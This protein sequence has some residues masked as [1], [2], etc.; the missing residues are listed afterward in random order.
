MNIKFSLHFYFL[1]LIICFIYACSNDSRSKTS[2]HIGFTK[3]NVKIPFGENLLNQTY[4]GSSV[5]RTDTSELLY[6]Y[7][8]QKDRLQVFNLS[9]ME[10]SRVIDWE[11]SGS[12]AI[13]GGR[14]NFLGDDTIIFAKPH[15]VYLMN[16]RG[17]KIHQYR[18]S[19]ELSSIKVKNIDYSKYTL[20]PRGQTLYNPSSKLSYFYLFR[21]IS[22]TK[23]EFYNQPVFAAVDWKKGEVKE[24]LSFTYPKRLKLED[25]VYDIGAL[26]P[27]LLMHNDTLIYNFPCSSDIYFYDLKTKKGSFIEADSKF[28]PKYSQTIPLNEY[29]NQENHKKFIDFYLDYRELYYDSYRQL[30]YRVHHIVEKNSS[31]DK[32]PMKVYLTVFNRNFD[33]LTEI[34]IEE[35]VYPMPYIFKQGVLFKLN[36]P[37]DEDNL[38]FVNYIF[39]NS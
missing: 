28:T 8:Y 9:K 20:I 32:L 33:I 37:I 24:Y 39:N 1:I 13:K 14:F 7:D 30:F 25:E 31:K 12:K 27:Y 36:D 23:S 10:F 26:T 38:Y 2:S 34:E 3:N 11:K 6:T 4:A 21:K 35:S 5:F 17:D 18:Y 15:E 16:H 22:P 19:T 29:E